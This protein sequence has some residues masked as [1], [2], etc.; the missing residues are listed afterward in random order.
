MKTLRTHRDHFGNGGFLRYHEDF[1]KLFVFLRALF[2]VNLLTPEHPV[3]HILDFRR[4]I[5]AGFLHHL[6]NTDGF[7]RVLTGP[8]EER[9]RFAFG[10]GSTGTTDSVLN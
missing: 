3:D 6:Q 1:G 5:L 9:D 2:F 7:P 8:R 10:T 4:R